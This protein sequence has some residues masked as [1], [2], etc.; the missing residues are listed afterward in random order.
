MSDERPVAGRC[1]RCAAPVGADAARRLEEHQAPLFSA[2]AAWSRCPGSRTAA[3]APAVP[4]QV[5]SR[6]A[7]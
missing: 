1:P 4:R 2:A 6:A 3:P 5:H 7:G